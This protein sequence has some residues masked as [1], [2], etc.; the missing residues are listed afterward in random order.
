MTAVDRVTLEVKEGEIFGFLGPNGAGKTTTIRMLCCLISKTSGTARVAG[1]EV[2][3]AVDSLK[4]R[5][6]IGLVPDNVGLYESLSAYD[7]LDF[8]GK[9]YDCTE[10]QRRESI[11]RFLKMLGLWEKKDAAAGTFSKGMKQKLAIARALIH[12]PQILFMDEPTANLDPEAAVAVR[13]IILELKK[14]RKT[15]FLNTHNLDEAQRI[16][17]RIGILNTKL[18]AVGTPEELEQSVRGRMTVV[19]LERVNEA[20]LAALK[21]LRLGDLS[22]EGNRIS[23]G[24]TSPEKEN[25]TILDAIFRAGG[26][27]QSVNVV[28]STLEDAYLRLVREKE[29][30]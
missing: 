30:A 6:L 29:K 28:G 9:F 22:V 26:R 7:N 2:G 19:Q 12:D 23:V 27:I 10:A 17:D 16:C 3:N 4:I 14:Q 13:E 20:V 21:D 24:V 5:K 15:I 1:Y 18:R 8:Y 25:P 11:P